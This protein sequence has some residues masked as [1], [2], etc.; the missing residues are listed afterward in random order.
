MNDLDLMILSEIL[1]RGNDI[2]GVNI[3]EFAKESNVSA[4]KVT[5]TCQKLGF[6]GYKQLRYT[7]RDLDEI[8][9][10]SAFV[11]LLKLE[12]I[13]KELLQMESEQIDFDLLDD[14][15][16]IF[17]ELLCCAQEGDRSALMEKLIHTLTTILN[18]YICLSSNEEQQYYVDFYN[19]ILQEI[20]FCLQ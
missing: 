8:S 5:K 9:N 18:Y 14:K 1:K 13:K 19:L 12:D 10:Q 17:H 6:T 16:K 4:S 3:F 7:V 2:L 11:I 15:N 20:K